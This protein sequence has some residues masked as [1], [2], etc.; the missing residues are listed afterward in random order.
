MKK[1]FSLVEILL[2]MVLF[3]IFS[4]SIV[5]LSVD[6]LQRDSKIEIS[7]D[8]LLYARE[9]LEVVRNI[10]DRDYLALVN[11]EYG[12]NFEDDVWSLTDSPP[13]IINDFYS[14]TITIKDAYRDAEGNIAETG[15]V[16]P[17]MKKITAEVTWMW[18]EVVSKSSSLTTYL[19][20]WRSDDW[21]QTTC[22]ELNEGVFEDVEA[23][24]TASPPENNC[25]LQ[26]QV[27]EE[28][29]S[30]FASSNIGHHGDDVVVDGNYAFVATYDSS[31]G[32]TVV[33][34]SDPLNPDVITT[35]DV[36]GKGRTVTKHGDYLYMGVTDWQ[37]LTYPTQKTQIYY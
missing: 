34:V 30:D 28:I 35:V 13:E 1:A 27:A 23:A 37:F 12:L 21:T 24:S 20:N 5:Y 33:D 8:S 15:T 2:A 3:T 17:E 9:G 4:T 25:A 29:T 32:L 22:A 6:T 11:G 19:A 31:D 26:I 14:R 7:N 18:Q 10:R 36:D 16:D